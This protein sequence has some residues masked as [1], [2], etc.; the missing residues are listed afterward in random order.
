MQKRNKSIDDFLVFIIILSVAVFL[1]ASV[2]LN[3]GTNLSLII[4]FV[5]PV[6]MLSGF[7]WK[8]IDFAKQK[9][10]VST[11]SIDSFNQTQYNEN[12]FWLTEDEKNRFQFSSKK[13]DSIAEECRLLFHKGYFNKVPINQD[14]SFDKRNSLGREIENDLAIKR[15]TLVKLGRQNESLKKVPQQRWE[16]AKNEWNNIKNIWLRAS[17]NY[18]D[19]YALEYGFL[20]G[21]VC[22]IFLVFL[23]RR[24]MALMK[25][26]PN[27]ILILT[28]WSV[29]VFFISYLIFRSRISFPILCP[30]SSDFPE[31]PPLVDLD[32]INKYSIESEPNN[33]SV[34]NAM[35]EMDENMAFDED[36]PIQKTDSISMKEPLNVY[37]QASNQFGT[38]FRNILDF[39]SAEY[40]SK[41]D[42]YRFDII[43]KAVHSEYDLLEL[44]EGYKIDYVRNVEKPYVIETIPQS[45]IYLLQFLRNAIK[46]ADNIISDDEKKKITDSI[47]RLKKEIDSISEGFE[48]IDPIDRSDMDI[49]GVLD[50]L[51]LV[52]RYSPFFKFENNIINEGMHRAA[53]EQE[54]KSEFIKDSIP[55]VSQSIIKNPWSEILSKRDPYI[56][57]SD[58]ELV[59]NFNNKNSTEYKI[60]TDLPPEP[61]IGNPLTADIFLLA[62]NPGYD[63]K[64]QGYLQNNPALYQALLNNLVHQNTNYPLFFLEERFSDSPG[65]KWWRKILKPLLEETNNNH[66]LLSQKICELQYFPY[67]SKSYKSVGKVLDS[68]QYTFDLLRKAI[69]NNKMII[70]L[71]SEKLWL[72]EVPELKEKYFKLNS[73]QNVVISRNN[74]GD[75]EFVKLIKEI[76]K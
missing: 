13:F 9:K 51:A 27:T 43:K 21:F 32:N 28:F 48:N 65:A 24:D 1:F 14:G 67:H 68:Q 34:P 38:S 70:V 54:K 64:E 29:V 30:V 31:L 37:Y 40:K 71:R 18:K 50:M 3:T 11:F 74:L 15:E 7:I 57:N 61:Y 12:D 17:R 5:T 55:I 76:R 19:T 59:E 44:I 20:C 62:L 52:A 23:N 46:P 73:Y 75:D 33:Y 25:S 58:K 63:G 10:K 45:L 2:F 6:V 41:D 39:S 56:L 53:S 35:T 66:L 22:W 8:R 36:N 26:N 42:Y 60:Y 47:I 16:E 4:S 72:E 69:Q 49:K